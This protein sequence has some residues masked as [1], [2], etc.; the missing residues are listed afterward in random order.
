MTSLNKTELHEQEE[1]EKEV[2]N[3]ILLIGY[4]R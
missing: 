4:I 1:E 3:K 2:E